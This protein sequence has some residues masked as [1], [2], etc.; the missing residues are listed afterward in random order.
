MCVVHVTADM[1]QTLDQLVNTLLG[2]PRAFPPVEV[3]AS[4]CFLLSE[5]GF[6]LSG[7]HDKLVPISFMQGNVCPLKGQDTMLP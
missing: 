4:A 2:T 3:L 6:D 5:Q 1:E 7:M